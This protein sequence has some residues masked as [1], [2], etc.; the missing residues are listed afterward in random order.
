MKTIDEIQSE[1]TNFLIKG[2]RKGNGSGV[3]TGK[4][5]TAL[6]I[7]ERHQR[8]PGR[9]IL[10]VSS[11]IGSRVTWP[12]EVAKWT[13]KKS[14][15]LTRNVQFNDPIPDNV[16][17]ICMSIDLFTSGKLTTR[18]FQKWNIG[19]FVIDEAH[20]I[21]HCG[22]IG[23]ERMYSL[24]CNKTYQTFPLIL[25]TQTLIRTKMWDVFRFYQLMNPK[26]F[27]SLHRWKMDNIK[28]AERIL[29]NATRIEYLNEVIDPVKF[30]AELSEHFIQRAIPRDWEPTKFIS[31]QLDFS[32]SQNK[33]IEMA[34]KR[35]F[36][37]DKNGEI[38]YATEG[39]RY[40]NAIRLISIVPEA[41]N[42][43][44]NSSK[45]DWL[46]DFIDSID[47]PLVIG[48]SSPDVLE[49]LRKVIPDYDCI[50]G[51]INDRLEIIDKFD[52][53]KIKV[54]GMTYEVANSVTLIN[55]RLMI[56]MDS[57]VNPEDF[58]QFVGRCDRKGQTKQ[59]IVYKL[60]NGEKDELNLQRILRLDS[61]SSDV[62]EQ[63]TKLQDSI[64]ES[65]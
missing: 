12:K 16:T 5:K 59:V 38:Y 62:Q 4:S 37:K 1:I 18:H 25:L 40:R 2:L 15:V 23:Y 19:A 54:L 44:A 13:D 57:Y 47:E 6:D 51:K 32:E 52:S 60:L 3:G 48:T 39:L 20:L 65:N 28:S 61:N 34:D 31:I 42:L 33:L 50:H 11:K 27:S 10:V 7:F 26:K 14:L 35:G 8:V 24:L 58:R 64:W 17:Y 43:K 46:L 29:S 36:I 53:G 22:T 55:C 45:L 9:R 63:K 56:A 41:L 30:R 49:H 21:P